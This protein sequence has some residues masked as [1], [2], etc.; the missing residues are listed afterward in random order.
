MKGVDMFHPLQAGTSQITETIEMLTH[1]QMVIMGIKI[2]AQEPITTRLEGVTMLVAPVRTILATVL[3]LG[4]NKTPG[5]RGLISMLGITEI[6]DQLV[7][8]MMA[9][10]LIGEDPRPGNLRDRTGQVVM[11]VERMVATPIFMNPSRAMHPLKEDP[12]RDN[13]RT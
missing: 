12:L 2:G 13:L 10:M 9:E 8:R 1:P 4:D 7:N 3:P 6:P 5:L 11:C